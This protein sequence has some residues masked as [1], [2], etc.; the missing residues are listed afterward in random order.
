M[1]TLGKSQRQS[2]EI[3]LR[4]IFT[5]RLLSMVY[6]CGLCTYL[7]T[8]LMLWNEYLCHTAIHVNILIF[9]RNDPHDLDLDGQL[10]DN[11][12]SRFKPIFVWALPNSKAKTKCTN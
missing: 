12:L 3:P 2:N 1:S 9:E 11:L 10:L 6:V 8:W 4:K 7:E 5:R